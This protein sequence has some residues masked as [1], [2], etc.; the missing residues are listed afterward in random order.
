MLVIDENAAVA[1]LSELF[2][3]SLGISPERA[4]LINLAAALHDVG[5]ES[6]PGHILNKPGKLTPTEYM[7]MK[8][9][10]KLGAQKLIGMP[11]E[12][13]EMARTACE[14]H[15]EWHNGEGYWQIPTSELPD[16]IPII[17]IADVFVACCAKRSYKDPWP[18]E[19]V[20]DYLKSRAGTQFSSDIVDAFIHLIRNNEDAPAIFAY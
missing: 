18:P 20:L 11:G 2:A 15:H 17:A 13:G 14:F 7:L 1:Q 5:K 12:L 3:L 4:R 10:T 8:S 9:H 19:Q 16:F 6:I